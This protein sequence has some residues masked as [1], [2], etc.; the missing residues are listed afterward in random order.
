MYKIQ[1]LKEL[2][3]S[4]KEIKDI[5]EKSFESKIY[6]INSQIEKL[7]T[8]LEFTSSLKNMKGKK[9]EA[10][11]NDELAI[12]KWCY[13]YSTISKNSYIKGDFQYDEDALMQEL[14]FSSEDESYWIFDRW[15]KGFLYNYNCGAI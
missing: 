11:I 5:D 4:L 2:G 7:K 9:Y 10:T 14:Y 6:D 3:F 12:G 15:P 8:N 13:E 1:L